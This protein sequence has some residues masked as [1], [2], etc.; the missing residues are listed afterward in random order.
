[1][2]QGC[3]W[4]VCVCHNEQITWI[5]TTHLRPGSHTSR[6]LLQKS[7]GSWLERGREAMERDKLASSPGRK[8]RQRQLS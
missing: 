4:R 8:L 7:S 6:L 3:A 2:L 1:M 5:Q